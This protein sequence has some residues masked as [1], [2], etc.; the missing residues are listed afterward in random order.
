MPSLFVYNKIKQTAK[1]HLKETNTST[2]INK[3]FLTPCFSILVSAVNEGREEDVM[4]YLSTADRT[5]QE[6]QENLDQSV[7]I[8]IKEK[9]ARIMKLL[10]E[11][12]A[13]L[14]QRKDGIHLLFEA[15]R[16]TDPDILDTFLKNYKGDIRYQ[17]QC[18]SETDGH[19]SFLEMVIK[20]Q[21]LDFV[22]RA[23]ILLHE[24][25]IT[26]NESVRQNALLYATELAPHNRESTNADNLDQDS[27][28]TGNVCAVLDYL[29]R[30]Q[31]FNANCTSNGPFMP[32][33]VAA[34]TGNV[35][36]IQCLI[37]H[38]ADVMARNTR[39]LIL[40][41][42]AAVN[43][44]EYRVPRLIK[45]SVDMKRPSPKW[46]ITPLHC[47]VK[48]GSKEVFQ[49]LLEHGADVMARDTDNETPL[50][51]SAKKGN[52][53][54][55]QCLI[56]HG[57]DV[58]ARDKQDMT[59][60]HNAVKHGSKEVVQCLIEHGADVM[61]K[62]RLGY[63]PLHDAV[64]YG[65]KEIVQCLIEHRADVIARNLKGTYPW[66][67]ACRCEKQYCE[68]MAEV[69][70]GVDLKQ[71]LSKGMSLLHLSCL[72]GS[73]CS[74]NYLLKNGI[75]V[76][77]RDDNNLTPLFVMCMNH[78][79]FTRVPFGLAR[80]GGEV[81]HNFN[82]LHMCEEVYKNTQIMKLL[83]DSGADVNHRDK[84]R[85]TLVM[86]REIYKQKEKREFL[87]KHGADLNAVGRDGL[88]VLWTAIEY[89]CEAEFYLIDDLLARN[90]DIGLNWYRYNGMTP[91]QLAYSK[92]NYELCD[93]LLDAGCSFQNMLEFI[94][95]NMNLESDEKLQQV[96]SRIVKLSAQ[97]YSLQE[98]S[99]QVVLRAMG[100]GNL[101]E[102][103]KCL[104][105]DVLKMDAMNE[106]AMNEDATYGLP[107]PV[108]DF[109]KRNLR[110][111]ST[112][113]LYPIGD[114]LI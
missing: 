44:N 57:A 87:I 22:K 2:W 113:T 80:E 55:I 98:L 15:F 34:Y 91:L 109:L 86:K 84:T 67:I 65:R 60:F 32:L 92:G 54:V 68:I 24:N 63:T 40:L 30:E 88:T 94:D 72:S 10:V 39:G 16:S 83:V 82:M 12:G 7:V 43:S 38:G 25:N 21:R 41:H 85:H 100:S 106:D 52:K 3:C 96:R 114:E 93:T 14:D 89:D 81:L 51:W 99:R 13:N 5:S 69:L 36:A 107:I 4:T 26:L 53:E 78:Q 50:H 45:R 27:A 35:K 17:L 19:D 6:W 76:N 18:V 64:K 59:P 90:I 77:C 23:F 97:P 62:D 75:D 73:I 110:F 46:D 37:N 104:N 79:D 111:E 31:G 74:A 58:M 1:S 8:A 11:A 9:Q 112:I 20:T 33:H 95:V 103:V 102:K 105:K 28:M 101:R 42:R 108:L 49:C 29:L 71:K 66:T 56:E 70:D 48:H 61:V 47:A